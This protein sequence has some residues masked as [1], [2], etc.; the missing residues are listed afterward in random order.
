M[1]R[2]TTKSAAKL[3]PTIP[4]VDK[5]W[6]PLVGAGAAII[7]VMGGIAPGAGAIIM[8]GITPGVGMGSIVVGAP[9]I[10][11]V[12]IFAGAAAIVGIKAVMLDSMLPHMEELEDVAI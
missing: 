4:P 2:I 3:I 10:L 8:G 6:A 9:V 12:A 5:D 7:V 11:G 1:R